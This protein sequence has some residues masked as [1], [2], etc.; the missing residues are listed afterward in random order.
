MQPAKGGRSKIRAVCVRTPLLYI[1]ARPYPQIK[2]T[3]ELRVNLLQTLRYGDSHG[4]GSA[5][6]GVVAHTQE[7]HHLHMG[8]DGG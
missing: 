6:H 3:A 8:R 5:H 7:A 2:Y 1:S 4:D